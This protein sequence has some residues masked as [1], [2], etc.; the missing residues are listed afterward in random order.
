[1]A[2]TNHKTQR[3]ITLAETIVYAAVLAVLFVIVVHGL[4]ELSRTYKSLTVSRRLTLSSTSLMERMTYEIR[5]ANDVDL[6]N[7]ILNTSPGKLVLNTTLA[8]GTPTTVEFSVSTSTLVMKQG[9][10]SLGSL[11]SASTTI[12]SVI[13]KLLTNGSV[14]KAVRVETQISA[15][16]G[17][18][19][20]T[21]KLY[22]TIILRGSY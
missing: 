14:S 3:G 11:T 22:N 16:S 18:Y 6:S 12:D 15:T 9:G 5:Q 17:G 4:L 8:D 7:S 10:T 13:F 19:S 1:M 20:K 21:A 2:L